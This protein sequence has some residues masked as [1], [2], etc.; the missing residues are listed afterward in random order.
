MLSSIN[1]KKII[2]LAAIALG[3]M[4]AQAQAVESPKF[5]DN[6]SI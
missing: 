6:W 2:L 3:A 1:M 4:S 5:F